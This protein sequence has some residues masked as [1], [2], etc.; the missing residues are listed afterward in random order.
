MDAPLVHIPAK[1]RDGEITAHHRVAPGKERMIKRGAEC[2]RRSDSP[3]VGPERPIRLFP[4]SETPLVLVIPYITFARAL[5]ALL[6]TLS[7]ASHI[8]QRVR[9]GLLTLDAVSL[10]KDVAP[11]CG[12]VRM[13]VMVCAAN[14]P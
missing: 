13:D 12:R 10:G 4:N 7:R 3:S 8:L 11:G 14:V 5:P 6:L 9:F 2:A 1:S